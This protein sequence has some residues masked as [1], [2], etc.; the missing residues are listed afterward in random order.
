MQSKL[1]RAAAFA[2]AFVL[3]ATASFFALAAD[4]PGYDQSYAPP[5][6]P[7]YAAPVDLWSGW[8]MGG[9]LGY[10]W[11]DS[12]VTGHG[13]ADLDGFMGGGLL[14]WNYQADRFVIGL[15]GDL[16]GSGVSG[17]TAYDGGE[18]ETEMN[19]VGDLRARAGVLIMPELLLF[20]SLGASWADFEFTDTASGGGS[21]S[22]GLSGLQ[23][24]AGAEVKLTQEWSARFDYL[25]TDYDAETVRFSGGDKLKFDPDVQQVRGS[26]VYKF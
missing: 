23:Y 3:S 25:Y 5:P 16:L 1:V 12:A 14:G 9:V 20:A 26:L 2:A 4:L 6:P 19:L 13:S 11:G 15:E 10:G 7:A 18:A 8:Y 22:V 24:G 17:S 21:K